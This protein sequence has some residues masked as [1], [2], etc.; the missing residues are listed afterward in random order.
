MNIVI[1]L[2]VVQA[3][4]HLAFRRPRVAPKSLPGC[5]TSSSTAWWVDY[6]CECER[7]GDRSAIDVVRGKGLEMF[8][9]IS[10]L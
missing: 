3:R 1:L 2:V 5:R 10:S 6:V 8:I 7:K 4:R 9:V